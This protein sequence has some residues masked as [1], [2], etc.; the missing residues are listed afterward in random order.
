MQSRKES[1]KHTSLGH[2]DTTVYDGES[3]VGVV[4]Y[5][6]DEE[7]WLSSKLAL[8]SQALESNLVKSLH[9]NKQYIH[10][11]IQKNSET[12]KDEQ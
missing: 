6:L 12:C 4:K 9:K 11:K 3:V 2:S 10:Q 5:D 8:I 7:L 1:N